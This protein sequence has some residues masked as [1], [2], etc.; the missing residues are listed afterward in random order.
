LD[1]D[2]SNSIDNTDNDITLRLQDQKNV[3]MPIKITLKIRFKIKAF[4]EKQQEILQS[5]SSLNMSLNPEKM[6]SSLLYNSNTDVILELF[7]SS[8]ISCV[9]KIN[10]DYKNNQIKLESKLAKFKKIIISEIKNELI[11][12]KFEDKKLTGY[13][14]LQKGG[15]VILPFLTEVKSRG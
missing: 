9:Y 13:Y 6:L 14:V 1:L 8:I 5:L 11:Q 15:L 7:D 2:Y 12:L 10:I 3:D 4:Q